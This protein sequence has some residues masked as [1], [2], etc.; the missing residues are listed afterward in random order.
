MKRYKVV[1]VSAGISA[2]GLES[3]LN[4]F[5]R[6][7][8]QLECMTYSS[9]CLGSNR[10]DVI[11][12]SVSVLSYWVPPV[13]ILILKQ[14]EVLEGEILETMPVKPMNVTVTVS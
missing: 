6:D 2:Q 13:F 7:G 1:Q 8:W 14:W 9:V 11:G 5:D 4:E 3:M 12:T 10:G